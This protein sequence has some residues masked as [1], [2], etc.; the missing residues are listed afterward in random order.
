MSETSN[1]ISFEL[2][3]P[4]EDDPK[5]TPVSP[6]LEMGAY[7]ALWDDDKQWKKS[8]PSF[9]QVSDLFTMGIF[10]G[11]LPSEILQDKT[12]NALDYAEKVYA[13]I[14]KTNLKNF[15]VRVRGAGEYPAKLLDATYPL[16]LLYYQGDWDWVYAPSVAVVG[17]RNPSED[18]RK[19][20]RQLVKKLVA[21]KWTIVSGLA[22]GIDTEAHTTALREG[23][24][25]IA[26]L[27][28]PL[29]KYYPSENRA[30]QQEIAA[31]FLLISQVPFMRY[32]RESQL[33]TRTLFPERNVT[34]SALTQATIIVEAGETSGTLRQ[35]NA[36][37]KQN[38]KLFILNS[39]FEKGL[40]WP[41]RLEKKGAIRV[42]DYDDIKRELSA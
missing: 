7:E 32:F 19:R 42:R 18:G 30:L 29:T 3:D 27:G 35:A 8:G 22:K 12:N 9:K 25:T 1:P 11:L 13:L 4:F 2:D 15:G 36:A 6:F 40:S 31:K 20:A 33:W 21:D 24:S 41:A 28:T 10:Q 26:V 23:G 37:F 39:C 14:E 34:M 38:R 16:E 17:T 5:H